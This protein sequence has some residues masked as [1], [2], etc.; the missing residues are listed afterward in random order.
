MISTQHGIIPNEPILYGL[1]INKMVPTIIHPNEILD[2]AILSPFRAWGM[3]TYS[4]QNHAVIKDLF[5][6]DGQDLQFTGVILTIA[7]DNEGEN[8][9]SAVMAG[10][11]AKWAMDADG[12]I[13]TKSGGGAPEVPMALVARSCE[14]LGIK[15]SL[16]L[17]HI[18]LDV[19]DPKAGLMMFNMPE[20]D[21]IVSMG[22]PWEEIT[23]P[24]MERIIGSPVSVG[25]EPP[26]NGEMV[27]AFRWIRGAQ[28][29]LGSGKLSAVL[30]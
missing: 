5:R 18:P 22:T 27:R 15:T 12:V 26:I 30:Y 3:E 16:A 29:Q 28:N 6:R 2:G 25:E 10:N 9:R 11:L 8:E 13:L 24:P 23:L 17:W 14:Q 1:N 20:L 7:S 21:A 4:I 19:S